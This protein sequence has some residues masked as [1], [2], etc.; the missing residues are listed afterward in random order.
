MRIIVERLTVN[1]INELIW[2]VRR[3]DLH[4]LKKL[5]SVL[6]CLFRIHYFT[7]PEITDQQPVTFCAQK[8]VLRFKVPVDY[9]LCMN[10][11]ET[12]QDLR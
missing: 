6:H 1:N 12:Q 4:L 10:E 8:E 3:L 5:C 11:G 2:F 9:V 7:H